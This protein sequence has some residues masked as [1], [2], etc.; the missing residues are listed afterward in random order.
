MNDTSR[1]NNPTG[2]HPISDL[3]TPTHHGHPTNNHTITIRVPFVQ[4]ILGMVGRDNAVVQYPSCTSGQRMAPLRITKTD[5]VVIL[6]M[7]IL[8]MIYCT[9]RWP[10]KLLWRAMKPLR[11]Q[12]RYFWYRSNEK[13]HDC[14]QME[15]RTLKRRE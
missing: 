4:T 7:T 15:V 6:I 14:S 2:N 5:V 12:F 13:W 1:E 10:F 11:Q 8:G 3:M 9:I